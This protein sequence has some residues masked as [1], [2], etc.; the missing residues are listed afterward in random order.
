MRFRR[1]QNLAPGSDFSL[2][3][4]MDCFE[5]MEYHI[6]QCAADPEMDKLGLVDAD[7]EMDRLAILAWEEIK[8]HISKLRRGR[9]E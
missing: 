3:K 4:D 9:D 7:P 2:V 6:V 1:Y 5:F 8:E